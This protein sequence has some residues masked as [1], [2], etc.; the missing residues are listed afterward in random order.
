VT[1]QIYWLKNRRPE[2]WRD[3]KQLEASP[4]LLQETFSGATV[5]EELAKRGFVLLDGEYTIVDGQDKSHPTPTPGISELP[6]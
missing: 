3:A 5:L 2:L 6:S 1:A 4:E